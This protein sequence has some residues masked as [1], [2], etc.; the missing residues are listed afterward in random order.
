MLRL[1]LLLPVFGVALVLGLAGYPLAAR[2]KDGGS[3]RIAVAGLAGLAGRLWSA[4][5]I[6]LFRPL[7]GGWAWACLWPIG[8]GLVD[9][10][11]RSAIAEDLRTTILTRRGA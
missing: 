1:D 10:Q 11:T 2:L 8:L 9:R 7:A 3:D 5:V 4:S 6:N